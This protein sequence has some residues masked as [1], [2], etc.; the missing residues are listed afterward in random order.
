MS[1]V[2]AMT[3]SGKFDPMRITV[4]RDP[5]AQ[6][7]TIGSPQPSLPSVVLKASVDTS[8]QFAPPSTDLT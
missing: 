8:V 5:S 1:S 4:S 3:G 2:V 7:A 6:R